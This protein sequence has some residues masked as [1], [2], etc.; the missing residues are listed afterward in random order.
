MNPSINTQTS[1]TCTDCIAGKITA[2]AGLTVC[3]DCLAGSYQPNSGASECLDCPGNSDSLGG[4]TICYTPTGQPTSQPTRRPS[5]QPTSEPTGQPTSQPTRLP[6]GQPTSAPTGQPST[7]PTSAPTYTKEV[8][9]TVW[10]K[11]RVRSGKQC[12][13][14]GDNFCS[15]H[16]SCEHNNQ[17]VCHKGMSGDAIYTGAD[18]SLRTCPLGTAWVGSI[19]NSNDM[20]P[21]AEC[22]NKGVCNRSDGLCECFA[23]YDGLACQ[24]HT[25]PENCNDRGTCFPERILASKASYV[26]DSP[27]DANKSVGCICDIGYR[28]PSCGEQECPSTVDPVG[29]LGSESGRDCSGRG[30]CD[31]SAGLCHCFSGFYGESCEKITTFG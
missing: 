19:I 28:G 30:V 7:T 4:W 18:C 8:F 21:I 25:C 16:G 22:S 11:R 3:T 10:D 15:G 31:Y 13:K 29:G 5:R 26:Y 23:G 24:R 6:S 14:T 27:W 12:P 17:C 2:T 1:N 9:S 20:H